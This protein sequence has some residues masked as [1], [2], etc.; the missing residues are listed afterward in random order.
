[1]A[2]QTW[3][4]WI[5]KSAVREFANNLARLSILEESGDCFRGDNLGIPR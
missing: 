1:M 3:R 2:L 5:P 4:P